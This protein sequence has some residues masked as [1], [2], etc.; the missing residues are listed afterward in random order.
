[1]DALRIA[2][3]EGWDFTQFSLR[4]DGWPN[5]EL[6]RQ[7][8]E[9]AG[10]DS[11]RI[12]ISSH[13]VGL[14]W[15]PKHFIPA[16]LYGLLLVQLRRHGGF[17][18]VSGVILAVAPFWSPFIAIGL[19]PFVVALVLERGIRPFLTWQNLLVALPIAGLLF[20]YLSSGVG[21]VPRSWIWERHENGAP[22]AI[23]ALA[24]LYLS[25]FAILGSLLL[26]LRPQL[27]RDSFFVASLTTLVLLPLYSLGH[28]NDFAMRGVMPAHFLLLLLLRWCHHWLAKQFSRKRNSMADSPSRACG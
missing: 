3:F 10:L 14:L 17:L 18:A 23:L 4:L 8:L 9:W 6:G 2:L 19:L 24:I 15:V 28:F 26:L 16:A 20:V 5:I 12:Q 22:A 7:H 25:E 13:M 1:M 11:L 21:D 27:R